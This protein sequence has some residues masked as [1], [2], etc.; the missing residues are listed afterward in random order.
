MAISKGTRTA[1]VFAYSILGLAG[2]LV[3]PSMA[4]AQAKPGSKQS[5]YNGNTLKSDPT[6]GG[7]APVHDVMGSWAGN[8]VPQRLEVPP[9]TPLGQKLYGQNRSEP[10]TGTGQSNDPGNTCDPLGVPRNLE[11]SGSLTGISFAGM[12]DRI[13]VLQEYQRIWRYAWI[14]GKHELPKKFDTKDGVPS[15][16]YGY[17][18]AHWDGDYTLVI[19]T[20][21]VSDSTWLDK[22]GHPHSV[23]ALIEERF[24]R[25]DHNH[26]Q[27]AVTVDDS[28][29]YTKP[30]TLTKNEYRWIPDQEEEEQ[31]CV[32][33]EMLHYMETISRPSFGINKG[34]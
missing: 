27:M 4:M 13:A 6:P 7:P 8:L 31:I 3:F 14:D 33:S 1:K 2:M 28:A 19:D 34:P 16:W 5:L 24:T 17:S 11:G 30:F 20:T 15:R 22:G 32:P 23:N 12:P 26:M 21:G 29:M 18:I 10:K 9:L 25:V